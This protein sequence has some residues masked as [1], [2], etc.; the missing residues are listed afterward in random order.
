[1]QT[2]P[3]ATPKWQRW[4]QAHGL[5]TPIRFILTPLL[6]K[7]MYKKCI[8]RTPHSKASRNKYVNCWFLPGLASM[9][10]TH[11]GIRVYGGRLDRVQACNNQLEHED[12]FMVGNIEVKA[13][14]TPGHT[15]GS[16]SYYCV[17]GGA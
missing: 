2:T 7:R 10:A 1:M 4:F 5:E 15:S 9:L 16:I 17:Q 8:V 12:V 13:L 3:V 14:H 11:F 6:T